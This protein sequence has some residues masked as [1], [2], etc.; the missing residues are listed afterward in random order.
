ME[1]MIILTGWKGATFGL[2][3]KKKDRDAVLRG[4]DKITLNLPQNDGKQQLIDVSLNGSFWDN[5]PEFR[6]S[7][8]GTWMKKRGDYPWSFMHPPKYHAKL[9]GSII[10]IVSL[11]F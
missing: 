8:I 1:T 6:S 2:R 11:Q 9:V 4:L 10:E 5:C 7:I 3:I